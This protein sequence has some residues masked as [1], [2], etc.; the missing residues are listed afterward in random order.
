MKKIL[1]AVALAVTTLAASAQV[2]G[3]ISYD[4]DNATAGPQ[5][6]QHEVNV[7]LVAPLWMGY[8]DGSVTGRRLVSS[9]DDYN[10]GF[11]FGYSMVTKQ[12][13]VTLRGRVG[14]GQINGVE[15]YKGGWNGNNS[16]FFTVSGEASMP[17]TPEVGGFVG[18]RYR[19]ALDDA[20]PNQNRVTL[21]LES[22]ISSTMVARFGYAYTYQNG[23]NLNGVTAEA[24][25]KF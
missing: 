1:T 6:S 4:Y 7:G 23:Y 5:Y 14:Y 20:G 10:A 24:G 25:Y 15:T 11:Q 18:Y 16:S 22:P 12:Q 19:G 17:F 9:Y 13:G 2:G 8:I 3:F 21:G